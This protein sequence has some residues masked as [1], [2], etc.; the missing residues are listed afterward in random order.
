M[1]DSRLQLKTQARRPIADSYDGLGPVGGV[2]QRIE[3]IDNAVERISSLRS[4]DPAHKRFRNQA[5]YWM[6]LG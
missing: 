3:K 4:N 2:P 5:R 6:P 1:T